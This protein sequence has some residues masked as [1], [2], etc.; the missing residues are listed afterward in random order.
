MD[1]ETFEGVKD[2]GKE[3]IESRYVI[4]Q[5]EQH[6]GQKQNCK[7][8]L[9]ARGFQETLK[10]QSDSPS[11]AKESFKLLRA[12][13]ANFGFK[14]ILVDIRATFMQSKLLDH[15]VYVDPPADVKKPGL[16]WKLRKPLYGL[17]DASPKFWLCVKDVFLSSLWLQTIDGDEAFYF[18]NVGSELLGAIIRHV[19]NF[20]MARTDDFLNNVLSVGRE[21]L[22]VSKVENDTFTLDVKVVEDGI[23]VPMEDYSR[24]LKDVTSIRKVE[25]R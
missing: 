6:D 21:E 7:A 25:D 1:Y 24:S 5:K 4:T 3:M 10:P 19:D 18:L 14:L 13:G 8:W 16:L 17:D 23:E 22:T 2:K 20:N 12:V 9:R 11:A 15:D